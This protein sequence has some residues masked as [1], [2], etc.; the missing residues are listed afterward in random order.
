ML[1]VNNEVSKTG[2]VDVGL[3]VTLEE[4]GVGLISEDGVTEV[5]SCTDEDSCTICVELD[6]A[7]TTELTGISVV[8]GT[9]ENNVVVLVSG[10]AVRVL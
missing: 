10:I 4:D 2:S 8:T 5:T 1:G 6:D 7:S 9:D 3:L